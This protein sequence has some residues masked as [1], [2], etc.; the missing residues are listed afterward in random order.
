MKI[1]EKHCKVEHDS[2]AE[3]QRYC[4]IP[5]CLLPPILN[6]TRLCRIDEAERVHPEVCSPRREG[7]ERS[8]M[9]Y[10]IWQ[11][12]LHPAYTVIDLIK[13]CYQAAHGAEHL[14]TDTEAARGYLEREFADVAAKDIP[15]CEPISE[16]VCRVNIAAWKYRGLPP[17]ELFELFAAS[18]YPR[19][20]GRERLLHY[21]REAEKFIEAYGVRLAAD[22]RALAEY[23]KGEMPPVHHSEAY[24]CAEHPA[25]RVVDASLLE[26]YFESVPSEKNDP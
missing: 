1:I 4:H 15:L 16:D 3:Y 20:N 6:T 24:R 7:N 2:G 9:S 13:Q 11:Y 19:E 23:R 21:L 25:Y 17:A 22:A 5:S 14:L 10:L 18:A 12:D 26:R 8:I